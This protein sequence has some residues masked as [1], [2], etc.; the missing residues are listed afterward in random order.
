MKSVL[1]RFKR[2][3]LPNEGLRILS[4][5][6]G[7]NQVKAMMVKLPGVTIHIPKD[8]YKQSDMN[9]IRKNPDMP[10]GKMA[11]ELGCSV[12]TVYRKRG[13]AITI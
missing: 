8:F 4:D 9:F 1:S 12:R 6:I 13:T 3:D 2:V 11:V 10:V 7:I 5:V